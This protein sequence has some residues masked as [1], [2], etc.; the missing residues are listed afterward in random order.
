MPKI[1][2]LSEKAEII[3]EIGKGASV[4]QLSKKYGV[5]KSTICKFKKHKNMILS[6]VSNMYDGP[7]NRKSLKTAKCPKMEKALYEWF[8]AQSAKHIPI[9]THEFKEKS[10][11]L[12]EKFKET[13]NFNAS[14]GWF[15][16][17]KKRYGLQPAIFGENLSVQNELVEPIEETE[18]LGL[19]RNKIHSADESDFYWELLPDKIYVSSFE[20]TAS[21]RKRGLRDPLLY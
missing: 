16:R 19:N 1:L 14:D 6:T 20:I 18:Q 2:T 10:K 21:G 11:L 12:C 15:Q 8:I 7:S 3:E 17:F 13:K 4:T 9:T 5:A